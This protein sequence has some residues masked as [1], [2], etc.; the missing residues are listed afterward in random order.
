MGLNIGPTSGSIESSF[1]TEVR[2]QWR[3]AIRI[4]RNAEAEGDN[5][6]AELMNG[7]LEDLKEQVARSGLLAALELRPTEA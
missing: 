3:E 2:A 6:L 1:L 4:R 7:R 5:W